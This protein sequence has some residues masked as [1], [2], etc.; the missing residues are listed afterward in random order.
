MATVLF[1]SA[2]VLMVLGF[3]IAFA[4]GIAAS[5]AVFVG[6]KSQQIVVF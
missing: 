2:F 6:G 1:G 4:L 3:P 5:A